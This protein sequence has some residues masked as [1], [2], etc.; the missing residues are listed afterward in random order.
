MFKLKKYL[1]VSNIVIFSDM[2]DNSSNTLA[3]GIEK[4]ASHGNSSK[5]SNTYNT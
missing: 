2:I 3:K 4:T 1:F 5:V